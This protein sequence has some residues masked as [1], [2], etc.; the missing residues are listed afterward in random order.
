[1]ETDTGTSTFYLY[2]VSAAFPGPQILSGLG[3]LDNCDFHANRDRVHRFGED[4]HPHPSSLFFLELFSLPCHVIVHD[5]ETCFDPWIDLDDGSIGQVA[6]PRA[7]TSRRK[8]R[9]FFRSKLRLRGNRVWKLLQVEHD[10]SRLYF[11]I[12]CPLWCLHSVFSRTATRY[13]YCMFSEN[14][15]QLKGRIINAFV[16]IKRQNDV[17][18][19]HD[20]LIRRTRLCTRRRSRNSQ[21]F[22]LM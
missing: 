5:N 1:M 20:S 10:R 21:Q 7:K 6:T 8:G 12:R 14:L 16:Q 3:E 4:R 19:V 15:S 11:H 22:D 18:L 17:T 9:T 13:S 2:P